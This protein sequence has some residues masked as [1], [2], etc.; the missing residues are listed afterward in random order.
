M[1]LVRRIARPLLASMFVVG[2]TDQLKHPSAKAEAAGP[3]VEKV[4]PLLRLPE[5]TELLVRANGLVMV[6]AGTMLALG[7]FPRVAAVALAATLVPTTVAAHQ[8][9][10]EEDPD[11]RAL[12]RIQLLKNLGLLGGLLLA[13]V[14][15]EGKPGLAYRAHLASESVQRAA[16]TTRREARHMAHSAST[17]ARLKAA[18]AQ[19][20]FS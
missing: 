5:D 10:K 1:S 9:W 16:R 6:G 17:E 3:V 2:G 19:H 18:Q 15:T 14:D 4:A 20:A 13:A 12:Q 11:T 8:Y 7:R